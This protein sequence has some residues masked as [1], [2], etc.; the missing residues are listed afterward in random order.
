[1]ETR[2]LAYFLAVAEELH[3]GR[4]ARQ[5]GIAQPPLSR[6]IKQLERRLGV[7]LLERGS[8]GVTLTPAGE[9]LAKEAVTALHAVAAAAKRAQRAGHPAPHLTVVMKPGGDGGLLPAIL[10]AYAKHPDALDVE[11]LLRGVADR[12]PLMRDGTADVAFLHD[13]YEDLSG[14]DTEPLLT[15][16]QVVVLPAAH[17]LA[18]REY[19]VMAD[20]EGE[21]LP[22]WH[23]VP[24]SG[25]ADAP[26]VSNAS[27]MMQL[28][29]LGRMVAVVPQ[30]ARDQLRQD[31][32]C[33]PVLDAQPVTVLLAW[34]QAS[35]S[36]ALAAFVYT[37]TQVAKD[38]APHH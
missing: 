20:L 6:A 26:E 22:R 35:R 28:I 12:A 14:F 23:G 29:A 17:R 34:P 36:P 4:A 8:R 27:E 9:V 31:L 32:V 1:M 21:T 16:R 13:R 33:I 15:E 3:F 38:H 25:P 7:T 10:D 19:I 24:A 30:S 18:D 2:E 5:L 11:V 37:A